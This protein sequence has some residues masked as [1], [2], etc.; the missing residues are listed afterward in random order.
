M[1]VADENNPPLPGSDAVMTDLI[2]TTD[3]QTDRP[4][5]WLARWAMRLMDGVTGATLGALFYG[6]WGVFANSSHGVDIALRSGL[7]QGL[8]SFV[9]TLTGVTVMRLFYGTTGQPWWRATRAVC[10][11]LMMIYGLIV[12]VHVWLG[13]P[14]ILLTLAPGLLITI[15]FCFIFTA[16][17]MRLDGAAAA[18]LADADQSA[19]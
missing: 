18:S 17:L 11:A 9:V 19:S 3:P 7:A 10:G 15:G 5:L 12:G 1:T 14:E 6:S 4:G 16:S 8:M 2:V 13:T